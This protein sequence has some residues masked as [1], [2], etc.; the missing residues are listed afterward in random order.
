MIDQLVL[1]SSVQIWEK[2]L[3]RW[4][5]DQFWQTTHALAK[6]V[7]K[8]TDAMCDG[9]GCADIAVPT[10]SEEVASVLHESYIC[11]VENSILTYWCEVFN[12]PKTQQYIQLY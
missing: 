3:F 5:R 2:L 9:P 7:P 11:K 8:V 6:Q 1:N 12:I 4:A 10:K